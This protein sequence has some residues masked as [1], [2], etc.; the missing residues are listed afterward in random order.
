MDRMTYDFDYVFEYV[1]RTYSHFVLK[2][3]NNIYDFTIKNEIL[4]SIILLLSLIFI[5][6]F[7]FFWIGK[8]NNKYKRLLM[9]FYKMY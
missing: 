5:F 7:I 4:F 6:I 2:D 1:F 9:F 3:I 8:G